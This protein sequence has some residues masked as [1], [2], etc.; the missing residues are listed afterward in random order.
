[1]VVEEMPF[2]AIVRCGCIS[3]IHNTILYI[4]CMDAHKHA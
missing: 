3:C 4:Q 1:M 2:D